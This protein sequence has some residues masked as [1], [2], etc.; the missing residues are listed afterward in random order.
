MRD[1]LE[2]ENIKYEITKLASAKNIPDEVL[3]R[4]FINNLFN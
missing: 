1:V 4:I 3:Q 2:R